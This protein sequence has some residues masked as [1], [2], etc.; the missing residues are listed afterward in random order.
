MGRETDLEVLGVAVCDDRAYFDAR[1]AAICDEAVRGGFVSRAVRDRARWTILDGYKGVGY[2]KTTPEEVRDLLRVARMEG[3]VLDP[4]YTNKA[5]RAL[6]AEAR[7]GRLDGDGA[8]VFL[9][10][11]GIF[12]LFDFADV[13]AEASHPLRSE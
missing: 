3:V 9:H 10:T 4:V 5:F 12:G 7:A 13:L 2:A 6:S 11:G 8:T 1:V